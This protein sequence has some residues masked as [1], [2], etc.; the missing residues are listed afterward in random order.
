M[1][2]S[3]EA[4]NRPDA[5]ATGAFIAGVLGLDEEN[6]ALAL[7]YLTRQAV[8]ADNGLAPATPRDAAI[9]LVTLIAME[10]P[11]DACAIAVG[12]AEAQGN[13]GQ[14]TIYDVLEAQIVAAMRSAE[15]GRPHPLKGAVAMLTVRRSIERPRA[16]IYIH[17]DI[18]DQPEFGCDPTPAVNVLASVSGSVVTLIGKF[19]TEPLPELAPPPRSE[20]VEKC[21]GQ[22]RAVH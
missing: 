22:A 19:L 12:F 5:W 1:P 17:S 10:R 13:R 9:L 20:L 11:I 6:A 7:M 21:F 14:Q 8:I 3:A 16:V 18:G 2:E 15:Q 4:T